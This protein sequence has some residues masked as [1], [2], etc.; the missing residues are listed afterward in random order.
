MKKFLLMVLCSTGLAGSAWAEG[1]N[2]KQLPAGAQWFLHMDLDGFKKT[3]LGQFALK[4]VGQFEPELNELAKKLQF[5]VRKDL[6]SATMFGEVTGE[7]EKEKM[8]IL[9]R[10]KFKKAPL[11]EAMREKTAFKI[12]NAAGHELLTW[13]DGKG[14]HQETNF[15]AIVNEGLII[16]LGSSKQQLVQALNVLKGKAPALQPRQLAGLELKK[17][18]YFLAGV[19]HV[20]DLPVP[21]EARAFQVHSLGFRLGEQYGNLSAHLRLNS[22][23]A[24]SGLKLQQM[25]QGLLAMGQIQL[26]AA[27][28]PGAKELAGVLNKLK[29]ARAKNV[30]QLDLTFPVAL[31][32]DQLKLNVQKRKGD[33]PGKVE[34]EFGIRG[35]AKKQDR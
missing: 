25:L 8:A 21:P 2:A 16:A 35:G 29:I 5:D 23:N 19:V 12:I 11:M 13:R 34:L 24:D 31:L 30:V 33:Q 20:K 9:F 26:A 7:G 32:L 22:A 18:G 17:G 3:Q 10:G 27:K 28:D 6:K 15:G 1:F 14:K 4:R